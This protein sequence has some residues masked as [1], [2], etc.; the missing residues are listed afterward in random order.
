[1]DPRA[2]AAALAEVELVPMAQGAIASV[3]D[4]LAR[5]LDADIP[6]LLGRP[7]GKS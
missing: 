3:K 4:I 2:A 7:P 6:A 1:M 5:C